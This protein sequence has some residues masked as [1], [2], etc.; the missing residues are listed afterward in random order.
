[1]VYHDWLLLVRREVPGKT[2]DLDRVRGT[3]LFHIIS[4]PPPGED[5]SISSMIFGT[6]IQ[7]TSSIFIYL[8]CLLSYLRRFHRHHGRCMTSGFSS[9]LL[10][11]GFL[12]QRK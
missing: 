11:C 8:P 9:I 12:P 2:I 10:D 4:H 5:Q 1:M 7:P 6:A 3:H